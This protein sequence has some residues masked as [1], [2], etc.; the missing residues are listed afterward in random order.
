M[1]VSQRLTTSDRRSFV[2]HFLGL[3]VG[4]GPG[5]SPLLHGR[6]QTA[7]GPSRLQL[8]RSLGIASLVSLGSDAGGTCGPNTISSTDCSAF[9][10]VAT[11][12]HF[13]ASEST[14]EGSNGA[15]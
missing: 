12:V 15:G 5:Q 11:S 8:K 3:E 7:F 4:L 2:T 13:P 9:T 14:S 10:T 1:F 6:W